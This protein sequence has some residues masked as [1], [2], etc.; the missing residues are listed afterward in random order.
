[1][2][3]MRAPEALDIA[4]NSHFPYLT[5]FVFRMDCV[6]AD[7][8]GLTKGGRMP[9]IQR[10]VS[11]FKAPK[12]VNAWGLVHFPRMDW[13]WESS[14]HAGTCLP[15]TQLWRVSAAPRHTPRT[16]RATRAATSLPADRF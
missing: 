3:W 4:A 7:K 1:M 13:R 14:G 11:S 6:R 2:N 16:L 12:R 5:A 10:T 15:C 9:G 8:Q